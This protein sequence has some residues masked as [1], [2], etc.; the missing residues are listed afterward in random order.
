MIIIG[1][2][3]RDWHDVVPIRKVMAEIKAEFPEFTY[4]HGNQRGFDKMSMYALKRLG[5]T[6]ITPFDYMSELGK[7]GGMARNK[8]MLLEAFIYELPKDILIV[9]MPLQTSIGTYGMINLARQA[10]CQIRI[11]DMHGNLV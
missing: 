8:R 2:G 5:H 7:A 4:Y 3:S 6:D 1:S 10:K 11:Y 9:A